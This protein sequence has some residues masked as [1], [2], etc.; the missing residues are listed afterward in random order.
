[1]TADER[2]GRIEDKLDRLIETTA[3]S[4]A[5]HD[6][7]RRQQR[8]HHAT[9]YGNGRDGIKTRVESLEHFRGLVRIGIGVLWAAIG[10]AVTALVA[11]INSLF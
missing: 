11:W 6:A 1:M 9:L 8:E 4:V 7:C 3:A 5:L 10:S 2:L